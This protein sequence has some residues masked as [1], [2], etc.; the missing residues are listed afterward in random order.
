MSDRVQADDA[1]AAA[2]Q[3]QADAGHSPG[4]R[5]NSDVATGNLDDLPE[6]L[7][8][9]VLVSPGPGDAD[10][11]QLWLEA[12]EALAQDILQVKTLAHRFA[13]TGR[14]QMLMG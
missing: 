7:R 10:P 4:V 3:K 8:Q 12:K 14:A 11:W 13:I 6:P 5:T 1:Y 9:R 2:L